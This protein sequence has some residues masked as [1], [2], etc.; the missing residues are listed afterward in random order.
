MVAVAVVVSLLVW[1]GRW[2]LDDLSELADRAGALAVFAL[3]W[4]VWPAVAAI[5]LYRA[6]TY[7]YR[8]TDRAVLI[9][10]GF[11]HRPVPPV[12]LR[13]VTQVRAGTGWVDRLLG[14]GWVEVQ[15]SERVVRLIGVRHAEAFAERVRA[16]VGKDVTQ[17]TGVRNQGSESTRPSDP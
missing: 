9:D 12:W 13:E 10:F 4:G 3:A 14:V 2:Y 7:T 5:Y 15:T 1:T 11:W 6:V 17:Q 16:A 8:L